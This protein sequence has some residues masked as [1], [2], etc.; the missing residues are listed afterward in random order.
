MLKAEGIKLIDYF[1]ALAS[2]QAVL[3]RQDASLPGGEVVSIMRIPGKQ[4]RTCMGLHPGHKAGH[5][6]LRSR[7]AERSGYK[8]IL[9]VYNN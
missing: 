2:F 3:H 5:D 1:P 8:V 6:A 4:D 7:T 9:T